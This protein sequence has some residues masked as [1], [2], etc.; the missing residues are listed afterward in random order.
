MSSDCREA[1]F[2]HL[3]SAVCPSE[4]QDVCEDQ[5]QRMVLKGLKMAA[6]FVGNST[7]IQE[8]FKRV[9]EYFTVLF[10]LEKRP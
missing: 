8:I 2:L 1:L 3:P 9:A 10:R 4:Y 7:A 5:T 6:A